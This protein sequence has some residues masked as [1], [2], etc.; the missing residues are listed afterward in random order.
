MA[1]TVHSHGNSD[2]SVTIT[3]NKATSPP[4]SSAS[5]LPTEAAA[6]TTES[7]STEQYRKESQATRRPGQAPQGLPVMK[8]RDGNSTSAKTKPAIIPDLGNPSARKSENQAERTAKPPPMPTLAEHLP[9]ASRSQSSK[10]LFF[11]RLPQTK[12]NSDDKTAPSVPLLT[13]LDNAR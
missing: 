12:N 6:T 8:S 5:G 9:M 13:S 2:S 11:E 3:Q 4:S 10:P 1:I 7:V